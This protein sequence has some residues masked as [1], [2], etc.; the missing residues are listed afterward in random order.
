MT[1]STSTKNENTGLY[2]TNKNNKKPMKTI[3]CQG[4]N[5]NPLRAIS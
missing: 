2:S 1:A 5:V 4:F 3:Q